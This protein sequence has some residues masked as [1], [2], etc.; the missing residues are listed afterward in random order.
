MQ[1][2][3][4]FSKGICLKYRY[5]EGATQCAFCNWENTFEM[6]A[7]A[8][9][10]AGSIL[11]RAE[12]C[13]RRLF[14]PRAH[15]CP[16][17]SRTASC[18][19]WTLLSDK[20]TLVQCCLCSSTCL[21]ATGTPPLHAALNEGLSSNLPIRALSGPR[22]LPQQGASC[23]AALAVTTS[24]LH[25]LLHGVKTQATAGVSRGQD[26]SLLPLGY[27]CFH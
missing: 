6:K 27:C 25:A 26:T 4:V 7:G 3:K 20:R 19:W 23:P 16:Q 18:A 1:E 5:I 15:I 10:S 17:R 11:C 22:L 24:E 21:G 2:A 9:M 12:G 8:L 13:W 14:S